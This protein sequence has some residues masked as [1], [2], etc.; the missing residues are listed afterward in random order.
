MEKR[1]KNYFTYLDEKLQKDLPTEDKRALKEDLLVQ[2]GFFQHERLIHLLVTVTF[3]IIGML[4]FMNPFLK[5][6]ILLTVFLL[7]VL[8]LLFPYLRFYFIL[9][10]GVQ[11]LYKYYDK[12]L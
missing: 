6:N 5:D 4:T 8:L 1:L 9:E 7:I 3:A 11:K 12:I 2:I 10:R